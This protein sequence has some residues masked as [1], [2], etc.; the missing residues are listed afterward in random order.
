[1]KCFITGGYGFLGSNLAAAAIEQGYSVS[2]FDN[3]SRTGSRQ[4]QE[5]LSRQ[6]DFNAI[7]EDIRNR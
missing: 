3:L 6:G 7:H 1:M 2:I 4:N 5:W